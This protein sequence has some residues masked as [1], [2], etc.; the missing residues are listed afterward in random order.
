MASVPIGTIVYWQC[1]GNKNI[2][3]AYIKTNSDKRYG[4]VMLK[5][6]IMGDEANNKCVIFLNGDR[7]DFRK[8]NL[9]CITNKTNVRMKDYG[10][11]SEDPEITKAGI[12]WCELANALKEQGIDVKGLIRNLEREANE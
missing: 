8:E 5:R 3:E 4:W 12:T 7:T 1:P 10:F 9:A 11:Y 6:Y 2:K